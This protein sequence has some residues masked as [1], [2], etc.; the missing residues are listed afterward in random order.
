MRGTAEPSH[1]GARNA[2]LVGL[3]SGLF[4]IALA[5]VFIYT[6]ELTFS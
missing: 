3:V 4:V 5:V 1:P 2:S 6:E